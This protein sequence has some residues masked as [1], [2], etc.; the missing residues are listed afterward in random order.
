[1]RSNKLRNHIC[2]NS[3]SSGARTHAER[4]RLPERQVFEDGADISGEKRVDN[5]VSS[6]RWPQKKKDRQTD[7]QT[8]GS[9]ERET[10][11]LAICSSASMKL[12]SVE[13][14]EVSS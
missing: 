3:E 7:R 12:A 1:M 9:S 10:N 13:K 2:V 6:A 4:F 5:V 14:Y 8:S 11:I